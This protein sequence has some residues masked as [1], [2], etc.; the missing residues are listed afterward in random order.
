MEAWCSPAKCRV[1]NYSGTAIKRARKA[2]GLT[3]SEV[4]KLAGWTQF[5]QSRIENNKKEYLEDCEQ[6]PL[7]RIFKGERR[8]IQR[9]R[10][11]KA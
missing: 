3:Q 6:K 5:K 8:G 9:A 7:E 2:L 1:W 4:A 11:T 10:S